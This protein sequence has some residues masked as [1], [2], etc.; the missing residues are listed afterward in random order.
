VT[1]PKNVAVV[2]PA[3][4]GKTHLFLTI[5]KRFTESSIVNY[6]TSV[7]GPTRNYLY[8]VEQQMLE[9]GAV[10][11]TPGDVFNSICMEFVPVRGAPGYSN[12]N[13]MRNKP[14][15]F[16]YVMGFDVSGE[17]FDELSRLRSQDGR[18]LDSMTVEEINALANLN[19][20]FKEYQTPLRTVHTA[21]AFLFLVNSQLL[22]ETVPEQIRNGTKVYSAEEIEKLR[23]Q[24]CL[25]A[26]RVLGLIL[27]AS[28]HHEGLGQGVRSKKPVVLAFTKKDLFD[29]DP[30]KNEETLAKDNLSE[31]HSAMTNKFMRKN[32]RFIY[33]TVGVRYDSGRRIFDS[34]KEEGI[35]EAVQF[36]LDRIVG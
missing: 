1:T 5:K 12:W 6:C 36:I 16:A 34:S 21:D 22:P 27:N 8:D 3:N 20:S 23:N 26:N 14:Q 18:T 15:H 2:G 7:Y 30:S 33:T 9:D 10:G 19:N 11:R 4:S 13:G 17:K 35:V 32:L 29:H 25:N 24:Y 28:Y 31:I